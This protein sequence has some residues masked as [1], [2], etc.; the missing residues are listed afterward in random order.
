MLTWSS[1]GQVEVHTTEDCTIAAF[2]GFGAKAMDLD[3]NMVNIVPI[4][5]RYFKLHMNIL[6]GLRCH[7][8]FKVFP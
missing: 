5:S 3:I 4:L 1:L 6:A 2:L 8:M 7:A